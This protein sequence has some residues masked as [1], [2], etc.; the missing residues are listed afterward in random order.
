MLSVI[1]KKLCVSDLRRKDRLI[2]NDGNEIR[3]KDEHKV[4]AIQTLMLLT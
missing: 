4:K 2:A 3:V 1:K